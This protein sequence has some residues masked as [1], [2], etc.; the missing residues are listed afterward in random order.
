MVQL[1][2]ESISIQG[3][4]PISLMKDINILWNSIIFEEFLN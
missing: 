2:I 3:F 4:Y 1:S